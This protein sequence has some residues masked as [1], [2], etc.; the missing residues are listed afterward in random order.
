MG[1]NGWTHVYVYK[2][3]AQALLYKRIKYYALQKLKVCMDCALELEMSKFLYYQ[4]MLMNYS[5]SC[6]YLAGF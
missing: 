4:N 2:V 5:L 3:V 6:L 1:L